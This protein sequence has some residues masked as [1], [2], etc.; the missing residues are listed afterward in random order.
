[1]INTRELRLGN[2]V[3]YIPT[4]NIE[5]IDVEALYDGENLEGII[6]NA[7]WMIDLGFEVID[8]QYVLN[9]VE[10]EYDDKGFYIMFNDHFVEFD[11]VHELQ[12]F[13]YSLK[14]E[15]VRI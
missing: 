14:Y 9:G 4:G 5:E 1:M 8:N 15:E 13:Y 6:L 12:N 10:I 2:L 11:F 7:V 3:R